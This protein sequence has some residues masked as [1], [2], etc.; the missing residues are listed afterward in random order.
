VGEFDLG[1]EAHRHEHDAQHHEEGAK[2][3]REHA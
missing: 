2:G 3:S 1:H